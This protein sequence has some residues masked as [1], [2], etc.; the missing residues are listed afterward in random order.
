[1]SRPNL[2]QFLKKEM[3]FINKCS[4]K[5]SNPKFLFS[6]RDTYKYDYLGP[7][8]YH[9]SLPICRFSVIYRFPSIIKSP[10]VTRRIFLKS[11]LKKSNDPSPIFLTIIGLDNV[12]TIL[13][14]FGFLK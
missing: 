10:R 14:N 7:T 1:M 13:C 3:I 6:T 12:S 5:N 9:I 11:C 4:E 2:R 8:G